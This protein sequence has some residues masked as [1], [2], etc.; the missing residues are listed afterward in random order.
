MEFYQKLIRALRQ[1]L[2]LMIVY[3]RNR[4][5]TRI[6]FRHYIPSES[7]PNDA[8]NKTMEFKRLNNSG[9]HCQRF[10]FQR[11]RDTQTSTTLYESDIELQLQ[12]CRMLKSLQ[13]ASQ[14]ICRVDLRD[15]EIELNNSASF[16]YVLD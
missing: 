1:T 5:L 2:I 12:L 16:Q 6:C 3:G 7:Y 14:L 11:D 9:W 8:T 10:N 13:I 15:R 4:R